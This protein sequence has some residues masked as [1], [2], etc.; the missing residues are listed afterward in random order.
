[1]ESL[2]LM[3]KPA[4]SLCNLRCSYCFYEDVALNRQVKSYGMMSEET[5]EIIV[6]R[7]FETEA[8][9]ISF[10][11]QGGEPSLA[12]D[13]F[14]EKFLAYVKAYNTYGA[15]VKYSFQTNGFVL[16][17][18][19]I[20]MFAKEKFLLGVSLD[21]P[22][23]IHDLNRKDANGKGSFKAIM[24]N[25]DKLNEAKVDYNILSVVNKGVVR[26]VQKVYDFY[27]KEGFRYLQFTPCIENFDGKKRS[28]MVTPKEFGDFLCRLFD[29][30]YDDFKKGQYMSIR[31]F[32]NLVQMIAGMPPESCAMNGVC[33]I[34]GVIEADGS[35]YPCDFYMLDQ[36]RLGNIHDT[37]FEE[38]RKAE[39]GE[40]F[41]APSRVIDES[42][43]VCPYLQLCRGGC[44]RERERLEG[45]L[46]LN[47]LCEGY[48]MF[49]DYAYNRLVEVA[50][51]AM[52]G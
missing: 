36:Y 5:I 7:A 19:L 1:M 51:I 29:L 34:N 4:S 21:G 45:Q 52:K 11:F 22:R 28:F 8:K 47:K 17:D 41:V 50:R 37:G 33:S 12:S 32:D 25:I 38:L 14:Y 3:I 10:A 35:V 23:E 2:V 40:A 24:K 46:G 44:R 6:K 15:Q 9:L 43:K 13:S 42:C 31:Y 26:H 49:F 27:K 30:W 39:V 48:R 16:S 18:A 20:G